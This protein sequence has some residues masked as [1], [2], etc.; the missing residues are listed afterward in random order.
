[1]NGSTSGVLQFGPSPYTP[2]GGVLGHGSTGLVMNE[3]ERQIAELVAMGFRYK[4]IAQLLELGGATQVAVKVSRIAQRIPG[5]GW[6]HQKL[7]AWMWTF[8]SDQGA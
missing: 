8:G 6:P 5:N 7:S 2:L 1:M 3:Q 4:K